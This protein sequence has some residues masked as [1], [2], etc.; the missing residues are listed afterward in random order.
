MKNT[1][2]SIAEII[3]LAILIFVINQYVTAPLPVIF[4]LY[5]LAVFFSFYAFDVYVTSFNQLLSK[6]KRMK[7]QTKPQI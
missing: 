7:T 5:C 2:K 1:S 3:L 4:L 6:R